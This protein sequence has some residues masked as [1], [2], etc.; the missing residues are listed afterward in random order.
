MHHAIRNLNHE[1]PRHDPNSQQQQIQRMQESSVGFQCGRNSSAGRTANLGVEN[2]THIWMIQ[3]IIVIYMCFLMQNYYMQPELWTMLRLPAHVASITQCRHYTW[4][5]HQARGVNQYKQ[6]GTFYCTAE[7]SGEVMCS[8]WLTMWIVSVGEE[9]ELPFCPFDHRPLLGNENMDSLSM[10]RR[11]Y[12]VLAR[13]CDCCKWW[14][15][16][17]SF[18]SMRDLYYAFGSSLSIIPRIEMGPILWKGKI[19]MEVAVTLQGNKRWR[20]PSIGPLYIALLTDDMALWIA[21][22]FDGSKH[23]YWLA[24]QSRLYRERLF[25]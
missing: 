2:T 17:T 8:S 19:S 20:G 22:S 10:G 21:E 18:H 3:W 14:R 6:V 5:L 12:Q 7:Q 1:N 24:S 9:V 16:V 13:T 11:I 15:Y 4:C 23:S 25:F